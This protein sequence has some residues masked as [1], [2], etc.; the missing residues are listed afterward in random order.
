[1]VFLV[2]QNVE[3]RM[4]KMSFELI[5]TSKSE[6]SQRRKANYHNVDKSWSLLQQEL[7]GQ[8]SSTVEQKLYDQD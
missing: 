1:M 8:F 7:L 3:I 2:D 5:R 4:S 6:L